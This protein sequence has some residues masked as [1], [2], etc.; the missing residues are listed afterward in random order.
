M[1]NFVE[2]NSVSFSVTSAEDDADFKNVDI[3]DKYTEQPFNTNRA[4]L[5]EEKNTNKKV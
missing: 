4:L 3:E 5:S 1:V 2:P